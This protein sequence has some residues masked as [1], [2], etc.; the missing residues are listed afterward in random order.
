MNY[1]NLKIEGDIQP[2]KN[3]MISNDRK[4]A[5]IIVN[6]AILN[7]D[8]PSLEI[9]EYFNCKDNVPKAK[10]H[11]WKSFCDSFSTHPAQS[12]KDGLGWSPVSFVKGSTRKNENVVQVSMAVID[13]DDGT[14]HELLLKR[15]SGYSCL[16][17]SSFSHSSASEK[18]RVILPLS[19]PV[20]AHEWKQVWERINLLAGGC[21]DPATKDPARLYYKPAHP[22]GTNDHFVKIQQGS[23]LCLDALPDLISQVTEHPL[24]FQRNPNEQPLAE[25][26]GMECSGPDLGFEQGLTEVVNRCAFMQFASGQENQPHLAEPLWM[27]MISNGCRFENCEPWIHSASEHHPE[28]DEAETE[29]KI[30][31]LQNGAAP[32]TCQRIRELGFKGCPNGGC[33]RQNGEVTKSPAGLYG[34]MFHRQLAIAETEIDHLPEEYNVK[35]FTITPEGVSQI[36]IK[37]GEVKPP[38]KICSRLDVTALTRDHDSSNWGLEL[39]FTDPDGVVKTWAMPKETLS[40]SNGDRYCG[41]LLKMGLSIESGK[42]ARDGLAAYLAAANPEA[43][44]LSVKQPGWFNNI[45]VLPD[46]AYG[47]S[48]ERVVFS[49]TDPDEIKRFAR[50]GTVESWK[51]N[52]AAPCQGNSRAIMSICIGLAPPLLALLGED[53]GGFHLRGNSSIGKSICLNLGSSPWGSNALIRTWNMTVN[54]LE[55]VATMHN[56]IV[57]PLDELGQADAKS[58]GE[59]AYMLGNGQ[60][61]GRAN[62]DGDART[63]KRWRNLVLSSGEKSM[64]DLMAA[65]GQLVMAG[66]EVRM[67][68][69]P[70]DAGKG[71]GVFENI[72]GARSSQIFAESLKQAIDEN[73]GH[74]GRI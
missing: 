11:T 19:A 23:F 41:S 71:L 50:K 46:A 57:L 30:R 70:A 54:G 24:I 27:A 15:F 1:F 18:Y 59:A 29:V 3:A 10:S 43:R 12:K 17:H 22:V 51:N 73:H 31:R 72:H 4:S 49:T 48:D 14:A 45:F 36:I 62:K 37:D 39:R 65:S 63:V 42:Q 33:R 56:D 5:V 25:I 21:N 2:P 55:G 38:L 20:P 7:P 60:G 47:K 53:N 66:Q 28:Y 13:V 52:V 40:G 8:V 64:A 44:A 16:I 67:I 6:E 35:S 74:A 34:W 26:D 58:A 32:I 69:I 9:S 68:E 61:K